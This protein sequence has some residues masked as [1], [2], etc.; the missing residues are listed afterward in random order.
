MLTMG[1]LVN[2]LL[3]I[4]KAHVVPQRALDYGSGFRSVKPGLLAQ[5]VFH[6]KLNVDNSIYG[7]FN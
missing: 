7:V 1:Q 2:V 6:A 3:A 4:D 5:Q